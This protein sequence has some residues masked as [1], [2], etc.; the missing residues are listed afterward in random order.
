MEVPVSNL[1][2]AIKLHSN[3]V[4]V[5]ERGAYRTLKYNEW[6]C[7]LNDA[8]VTTIAEQSFDYGCQTTIE[9]MMPFKFRIDNMWRRD[10]LGHWTWSTCRKGIHTNYERLDALQDAYAIL[11]TQNAEGA[12]LKKVAGQVDDKATT[13]MNSAHFHQ[14]LLQTELPVT[15]AIEVGNKL[16]RVYQLCTVNA[17]RMRV[18]SI[19]EEFARLVVMPDALMCLYTVP[20]IMFARVVLSCLHQSF[21]DTRQFPLSAHFRNISDMFTDNA[22]EIQRQCHNI[23]YFYG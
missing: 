9:S 22:K 18:A 15:E 8:K 12:S 23:V 11:S 14:L 2:F 17:A 19:D 3:D 6:V 5:K 10:L 1:V 20:L 13:A 4:M 21:N 16:A 7:C